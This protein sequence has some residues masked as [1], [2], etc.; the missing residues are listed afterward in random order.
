[1]D[2]VKGPIRGR[3]VRSQSPIANHLGPP[4]CP[5]PFYYDASELLIQQP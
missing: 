2:W 3:L 1:M 5:V 4:Q